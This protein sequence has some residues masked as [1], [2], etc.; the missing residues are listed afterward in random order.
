MLGLL[1]GVLLALPPALAQQPRQEF[2][3]RGRIEGILIG[4]SGPLSEVPIQVLNEAGAVLLC[5]LTT[6][7][8]NFRVEGLNPGTYVIQAV[9]CRPS[10]EADPPAD[11]DACC[12][13]AYVITT[14]SA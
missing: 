7:T 6:R 11:L 3:G 10:K 9:S 4:P 5:A 14:A 2:T 12:D 1:L 13:T 8:G